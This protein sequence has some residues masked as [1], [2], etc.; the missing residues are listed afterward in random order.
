MTAV[1]PVEASTPVEDEGWARL[2]GHSTIRCAQPPG[3]RFG[4]R[5]GLI[6]VG[7]LALRLATLV[8]TARRNPTGGDP[9]YYHV[10]ANLLAAGHGFAEPFRWLRDGRVVAS[11]VHPP[12]WSL[13]LAS[14]SLFGGTS[15]LAHKVVACLVGTATVVVVGWAAREIGGARVG[16]IAAGLAALYPELW[17]ID[18]TLM[19]EGLAALTGALVVLTTYRFW[20]RPAAGRA[21]VLGA[22]IG[23]AALARGEDLLLLAI[24]AVPAVVVVARRSAT[25]AATT[26]VW[27]IALL[28]SAAAVVAPWSIRNAVTFSKPVPISV[29]SEEVLANANCDQTWHGSLLGFWAIDCY[30][31]NP[32]G[33]ESQRAAYWR[34]EGL[35]YVRAHL[36]RLPVVVAARV[37]RV[38]DLYRP[39]ENARLS[40]VEGRNLWVARAGLICYYLLLPLAAFGALTL[41]RR[42]V[43]LLPLSG[44]I[45]LVTVTAIYAY[46]ATRFRIPSEIALVVLAAVALDALRPPR[47]AAA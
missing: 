16:L 13:V 34:T 14:S 45:I 8:T 38:W 1:G 15:L 6:A 3:R 26:A 36:S 5:L 23:V 33:D 4:W 18:G 29:N 2:R 31:G 44:M 17:V 39:W 24:V 10:Q 22:A 47:S 37:G 11:A 25:P 9:V 12:L 19:P 30:R 43:P 27:T 46:G 42:G 40:T 20:H 7:A 41:R 21:A 35:D 32:S 28:A